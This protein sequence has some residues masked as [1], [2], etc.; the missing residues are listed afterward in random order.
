MATLRQFV[1]EQG[2]MEDAARVIGVRYQTVWRWLR[3]GDRPKS[4]VTK[5]RL[6]ELGI[7]L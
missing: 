2:T 1:K 4:Q 7:N 3:R 6:R 5:D